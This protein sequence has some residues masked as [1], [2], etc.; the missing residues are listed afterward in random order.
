MNQVSSA[1]VTGTPKYTNELLKTSNF[2]EKFLNLTS[3]ICEK[4]FWFFYKV[5]IE[6]TFTLLTHN[7]GIT[8]SALIFVLFCSRCIFITIQQAKEVHTLQKQETT[9]QVQKSC[10]TAYEGLIKE[11]FKGNKQR[12]LDFCIAL[13]EHSTSIQNNAKNVAISRDL[14]ASQKRKTLEDSLRTLN[15]VAANQSKTNTLHLDAL[16]GELDF[17]QHQLQ[18]RNLRYL[19]QER[20]RAITYENIG[21]RQTECT[22]LSSRFTGWLQPD[23]PEN[24]SHLCLLGKTFIANRTYCLLICLSFLATYKMLDSC[25]DAAVLK[26]E[27]FDQFFSSVVKSVYFELPTTSSP[28]FNE[29]FRMLQTSNSLTFCE[30]LDNIYIRGKRDIDDV[31]SPSSIIDLH[32]HVP[33]GHKI[34]E[35]R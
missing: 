23:N 14:D 31:I 15:T 35:T 19:A 7:N 22:T 10:K 18:N 32:F 27:L 17:L 1:I 2:T 16:R 24:Y 25:Q 12:I 6:P 21:Q 30:L 5:V 11:Q 20:L 8:I 9:F 13:N 33:S 3:K 26:F 28:V 29:S 4:T 34:F